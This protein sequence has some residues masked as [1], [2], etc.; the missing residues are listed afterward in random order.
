MK[1]EEL[2][3]IQAMYKKSQKRVVSITTGFLD[4][5]WDEML[6]LWRQVQ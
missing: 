2:A 4:R 1:K 6:H 3:Q 5:T